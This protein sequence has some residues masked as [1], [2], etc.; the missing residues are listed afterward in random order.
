MATPTFTWTVTTSTTPTMDYTVRSASFGDG[1][2]QTA[3]EG[4][5]NKTESWAITWIGTK[6]D[7]LA[8]MNFFDERAGWK[9]FYWTTPLG[10]LGLFRATAPTATE[11]GGRTFQITATFTKAYAA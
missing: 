2:V 9:S 10:K 4:I 8:I 3:G 7:C 11:M 5:N 1:Y 6:T